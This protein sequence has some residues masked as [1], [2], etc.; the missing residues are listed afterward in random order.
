M[1]AKKNRGRT[2]HAI[3]AD[4]KRAIETAWNRQSDESGTVTGI[5]Y[6]TAIKRSSTERMNSSLRFGERISGNATYAKIMYDAPRI[7]RPE[8]K[9]RMMLLCWNEAQK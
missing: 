1:H 9:N 3:E 6:A 5:I 8:E 2:D 7:E 4:A